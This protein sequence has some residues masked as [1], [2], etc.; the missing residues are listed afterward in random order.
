MLFLEMLLTIIL[1]GGTLA[2]F[3]EMDSNSNVIYDQ[4]GRFFPLSFAS[5]ICP[6][7]FFLQ[8]ADIRIHSLGI[9]FRPPL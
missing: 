2:H 5:L 3:T 6:S 9:V 4:S 8:T 7:G 1:K